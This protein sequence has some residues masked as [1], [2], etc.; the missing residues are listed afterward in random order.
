MATMKV[1]VTGATGMIGQ[2]LVP[3]LLEHG[4][5]LVLVARSEDKLKVLRDRFG[6][7]VETV[8]C[9]LR[10][11]SLP[12]RLVEGS[13]AVIHLA[14]HPL[15]GRWTEQ[16]RRAVYESRLFGTKQIVAAIRRARRR[17]RVLLSASATGF[18]GDRNDEI[19]TEASAP[20]RDFL[21]RLTAEWEQ[22]ALAGERLGVRVVTVRTAPVVGRGG[23]LGL[24]VPAV[25]L[26]VGVLGS[27]RQWFPWIHLSDIANIYVH[28]LTDSQ[29]RGPLNAAAPDLVRQAEFVRTLATVM[30][31]PRPLQVP[32]WALRLVY[33]ELGEAMVA[34]QRVVPWKL[35]RQNYQFVFPVLAPALGEV[36]KKQRV[37]QRPPARIR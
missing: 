34:S 3:T 12:T 14:G 13:R 4:Y 30:R 27:G 15:S 33:G 16:H 22:E 31:V 25:E 8:S 36:V 29:I 23:F 5:H 9:D 1:V 18:Y 19:L 32:V 10:R 7:V 17:P 21:A 24:L 28:A 26:G 37:S 6:E 35:R 20:G 2:A 11:D